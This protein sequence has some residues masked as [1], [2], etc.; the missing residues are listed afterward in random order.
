MNAPMSAL[1]RDMRRS[2][3]WSRSALTAGAYAGGSNAYMQDNATGDLR[4]VLALDDG[5]AL[6]TAYGSFSGGAG[7]AGATPD[8]SHVLFTSPAALV[9]G[10]T[11]Y[12]IYELDGDQVRL[13]S[14]APDE[15]PLGFQNVLPSATANPISA[16][17]RRI[18]WGHTRTQVYM[19]EDGSH[20]VEISRPQ[21]PGTDPDTEY[22]A[23]FLYATPD[24]RNVFFQSATP[25]SADAEPAGPTT[26]SRLYRW[27][28]GDLTE[29]AVGAPAPGSPDA[30]VLAA[31]DDGDTVYY[32]NTVRV[33]GLNRARISVWRAGLGSHTIAT[34]DQHPI[35]WDSGASS[36]VMSPDGKTF[37]FESLT[38]LTGASH[39]NDGCFVGDSSG[40]YYSGYCKQLY[41]YDLAT[42]A[43]ACASCGRP[44]TPAVGFPGIGEMSSVFSSSGDA[45]GG[46]IPSDLEQIYRPRAIADDGTVFFDSPAQLTGEDTDGKRDVYS[47]RSGQLRLLSPGTSSDAMFATV[48]PDGQS[49][50]FATNDRLV[51]QDTDNNADVYVARV[52]GGLTGQLAAAS[53]QSCEGDRCQGSPGKPP[54][55]TDVSTDR[56][57][58]GDLPAP[59]VRAR[60]LT[61]LSVTNPQTSRTTRIIVTIKAPAAGRVTVSGMGLRVGTRSVRA[62]QTVRLTVTLSASAVSRLK[63]RG[64]LTVVARVGFAPDARGATQVRSVRLTFARKATRRVARNAHTARSTR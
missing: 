7:V 19:R 32:T 33:A 4:L 3:V 18:F 30:R 52:N 6:D 40:N 58:G 59:A 56:P 57:A 41:V 53:K 54:A 25:L 28:D 26:G 35:R 49:V 36:S 64:R 22:F 62:A 55:P 12:N 37:A 43:L 47:Y 17:G 24:G 11:E 63:A 10:A 61:K 44:G 13:V 31:T 14:R 34:L 42:D 21:R 38:E 27:R 5:G 29:L 60:Q 8:L 23:D 1:S 45:L 9:P 48:T 15:T 46:Y 20:T 16:D 2:L 51:G 39:E 50:V